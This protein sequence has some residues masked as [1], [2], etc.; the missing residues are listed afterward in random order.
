MWPFGKNFL[1]LLRNVFLFVA[2]Q[3]QYNILE[4]I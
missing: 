1:V 2:N 4:S 3:I